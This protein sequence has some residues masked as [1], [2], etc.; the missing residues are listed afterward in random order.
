MSAG[1]AR[2]IAFA[3]T[4]DRGTVPVLTEP[5]MLERIKEKATGY[6]GAQIEFA[7]ECN[8]SPQYINDI[9]HGRRVVTDAVSVPLGYRRVV[10]F[11]PIDGEGG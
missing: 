3:Y 7:A 1:P 10:I 6:K 9:V 4:T 5:E 8:C 11:V 2:L